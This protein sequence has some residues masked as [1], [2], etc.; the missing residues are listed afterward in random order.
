MKIL[1]IV[2]NDYLAQNGISVVTQYLAE[3]LVKRGHFVKVYTAIR[4]ET[5]PHLHNGVIIESFDIRYNRFKKPVGEIDRFKKMVA[6]DDSNAII[7][8]SLQTPTADCLLD[9]LKY[10]KAKK[11]LH[12]HDFEGLYLTPIKWKGDLFHTLGNTVNYYTWKKYYKYFVP[13]HINTFDMV[14]SLTKYNKD[15][16]YLEKYYR[17]N[18]VI[19]GNAAEDAF[20]EYDSDKEPYIAGKYFV[21]VANYNHVK[22][23]IYILTEYYKTEASNDYAMCFCGSSSNKYMERLRRLKKKL[24]QKYGERKVRFLY[25]IERKDISNLIK[26]ATLY[27]CGSRWEAYSISIIEAMALG[28]P[29]ISLDVGNARELPGGL[30]V[31]D[32][33]FSRTIDKV[34]SDSRLL[35]EIAV[36]GEEYARH[37]CRIKHAVDKLETSLISLVESGN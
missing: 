8:V 36:A 37:K 4:E 24:D 3:G 25:G 12:T 1:F 20:F 23:Q 31:K 16:Q 27:L 26:N 17:G 29:F 13:R 19:I 32:K 18:K 2:F 34:C 14:I 21:S 30:T 5:K 15:V 6:E 35:N 9:I 28:T 33:D 22:N 11:I 10:K 7:V